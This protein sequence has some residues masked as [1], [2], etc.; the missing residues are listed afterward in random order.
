[1]AHYTYY[2]RDFFTNSGCY[3]LTGAHYEQLLQ[4][5]FRYSSYVSFL[6]LDSTHP[7]AS[8]LS[9]WEIHTNNTMLNAILDTATRCVYHACE[10]LHQA[11][12]EIGD[13][14]FSFYTSGEH[15]YP[16]DP[17]FIR[18]DG[19]VFFDSTIHEGE[20]SLYPRAGECIDT[21]LSWGHWLYIDD[22][23]NPRVP[24]KAHQ[25]PLPHYEELQKDE[26]YKEL[27]MIQRSPSNY[28][29]AMTADAICDYIKKFRPSFLKKAQKLPPNISCLPRW[30]IAFEMYVLGECNELTF[31]DIPA[32]LNANGYWERKGFD[33]FFELLSKYVR[34]VQTKNND[35]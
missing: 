33:R 6:R 30:Y 26:L 31:T 4:C 11:M 21:V 34:L 16:E 8:K 19:S 15:A 10:E 1:M 29:S 12:L 2:L 7:F 23:G 24:A 17:M 28:L 25:F 35:Q 14:F 5:C 32:A 27:L 13:D 22:N 20:C 18:D 3:P 9:K